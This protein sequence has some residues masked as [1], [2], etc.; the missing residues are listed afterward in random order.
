MSLRQSSD[1]LSAK[2]AQLEDNLLRG[3]ARLV[4]T[5]RQAR[6]PKGVRPHI[7]DPKEEFPVTALRNSWNAGPAMKVV[8]EFEQSLKRHPPI[9]P[10]TP[11][12]Y[13]PK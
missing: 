5:A 7:I 3:A 10:G 6:N 12:P 13:T 11:D 2:V 9:A 1:V 4:D 8:V